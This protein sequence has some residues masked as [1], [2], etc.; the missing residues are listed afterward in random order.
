[1]NK[2]L[3]TDMCKLIKPGTNRATISSKHIDSC[4]PREV[5]Y[6]C[7][8]W[9]CHIQQ[10]EMLI[11]GDGPVN[12]FLLQHFLHWLEAVS[13]IGRTSDSLNILKSLQSA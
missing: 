12:A 11:D 1:M 3:E 6:A 5:Q 9:V 4:I 7:L 13:L 2:H 10:A 8:Y